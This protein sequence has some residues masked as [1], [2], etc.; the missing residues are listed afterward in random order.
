[1]DV[2]R[3]R[4][5][6]DFETVRAP[7]QELA[8]GHPMRGWAW[9]SSWW[10]HYGQHERAKREL[11][12]LVVSDSRRIV[13]IAPWLVEQSPRRGRVIR[14]LGED[15]VC[16]DYPTILCRPPDRGRAMAA[17]AEYLAR[18]FSA[19]DVL[20]LA[21]VGRDDATVN[22]LVAHFGES[23]YSKFTRQET[24]RCWK[25]ALPESWDEFQS[26]LAKPFRRRLRNLQQRVV[27]AGRLA[28]H[29]VTDAGQFDAAWDVLVD[30]HQ[31]RRQSLGEPGCFT[32]RQFAS[33]HYEVARQ[34]LGCG[35]L[36]LAW[37]ELDGRPV[38]ADYNLIGPQTTFTYQ[39]GIEPD[40]LHEQPGHLAMM[41]SIRRAIEQGHEHFNF[42]RGDEPY[43]AQWRAAPEQMF[44][45]RVVAQRAASQLREAAY[46]AVGN[47]R[48]WLKTGWQLV[49]EPAPGACAP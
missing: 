7:W 30:L 34:L 6:T 13:A 45:V 22:E 41:R 14:F 1:M 21:G 38:S 3:L 37:F 10:T 23:G 2:T 20:E 33:F 32:S 9:Q 24:F 39:G 15:E 42:L 17:V 11:F 44:T 28:V 47:F 25:A 36:A 19:W 8:A 49:R 18:E 29:D 27:D 35:Q 43:K 40:L 46:Q 12:T 31:R 16:T 5:L 4:R 26:T 48:Q